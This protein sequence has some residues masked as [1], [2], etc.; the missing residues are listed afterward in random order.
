MDEDVQRRAGATRWLAWAAA[1]LLVSGTVSPCRVRPE[2]GLSGPAAFEPPTSGAADAIDSSPITRR[3]ID[4]T[5]VSSWRGSDTV[6][7]SRSPEEA[8]ECDR[9][10]E[11]DDRRSET[12]GVGPA[13]PCGQAT[14][15]ESRGEQADGDHLDGHQVHGRPRR[16][17][18]SSPRAKSRSSP[19]LSFTLAGVT[20]DPGML[21]SLESQGMRSTSGCFGPGRS[22][23]KERR[24][25]VFYRYRGVAQW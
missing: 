12:P 13:A 17:R 18:W 24:S 4:P 7:Q 3:I 11:R 6:A 19:L 10:R 15:E 14:T 21:A 1:G 23:Q 22:L 8:G 25:E 20:A 9:P 2:A 5:A 16:P